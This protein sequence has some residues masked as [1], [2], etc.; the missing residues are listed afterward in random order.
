MKIQSERME[1]GMWRMGRK[2]LKMT[3][4]FDFCMRNSMWGAG[5]KCAEK[6]HRIETHALASRVNVECGV[7][8]KE[9]GHKGLYILHERS[10]CREILKKNIMNGGL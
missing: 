10:E 5:T 4:D 1:S 2:C 7:R 3:E 8:D 6:I 9:K